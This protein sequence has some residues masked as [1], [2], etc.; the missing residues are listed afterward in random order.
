MEEAGI[1]QHC[2]VGKRAADID[3]NPKSPRYAR[4]RH[5]LFLTN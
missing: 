3:G 4:F 2:N 1:G 5:T